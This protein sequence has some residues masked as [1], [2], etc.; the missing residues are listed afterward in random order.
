[1]RSRRGGVGVLSRRLSLR[2]GDGERRLRE[3]RRESSESSESESVPDESESESESLSEEEDSA[4]SMA[5][6]CSMISRGAFFRC[7]LISSVIAPRP[8]E[9]K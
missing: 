1:M 3:P 8:M 2:L 7:S 5:R 6:R 4:S 9:V